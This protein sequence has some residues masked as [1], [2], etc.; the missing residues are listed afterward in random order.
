MYQFWIWFR[1]IVPLFY[2]IFSLSEVCKLLKPLFY[3]FMK[4]WDIFSLKMLYN[5]YIYKGPSRLF[6]H[7]LIW[8]ILSQLERLKPRK[9]AKSEIYPILLSFFYRFRYVFQK[10]IF[11]FRRRLPRER[12]RIGPNLK[13]MEVYEICPHLYGSWAI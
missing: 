7:W 9:G 8:T 12:K 11:I 5:I 6:S 13:F 3:L 2:S 1:N 10:K 4:T